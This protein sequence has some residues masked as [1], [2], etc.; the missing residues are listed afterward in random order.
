MAKRWKTC[1]DLNKLT[2]RSA[3]KADPPSQCMPWENCRAAPSHALTCVVWS[4]RLKGCSAP[5]S[6]V[7]G[8][9]HRAD[10]YAMLMRPNKAETAVLGFHCPGDM[11]VGMRKVLARPWVK[12]WCSRV[13]LSFIVIDL[14]AYLISTKVMSARHRNASARK[15]WCS[16][17][18]SVDLSFQLASTCKSIWPGLYN[19]ILVRKVHCQIHNKISVLP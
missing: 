19:S 2:H 10:G 17:P 12:G 8:R 9:L 18:R 16:W 6:A 11:A 1:I 13:S 14:N 7:K 5:T 15:A 4:R 3:I